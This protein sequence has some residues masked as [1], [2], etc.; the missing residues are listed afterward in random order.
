MSAS[1]RKE[2]I[3]KAKEQSEIAQA[4]A[5]E[6]EIIKNKPIHYMP[7][8]DRLAHLPKAEAVKLINKHNENIRRGQEL[9]EAGTKDIEK[10]VPLDTA[11]EK[12]KR[13]RKKKVE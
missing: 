12:P 8:D 4:I 7:K 10:E 9:I 11:P 2:L 1:R 13:G 6:R 3:A 5:E